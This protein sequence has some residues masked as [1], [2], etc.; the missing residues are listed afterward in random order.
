MERPIASCA[1]RPEPVP[2]PRKPSVRPAD[3]A[4]KN[5]VCAREPGRP[6]VRHHAAVLQVPVAA[7][8]FDVLQFEGDAVAGNDRDPVRASVGAPAALTAWRTSGSA[9]TSSSTSVSRSNSASNSVGPKQN[10][11]VKPRMLS[12]EVTLTSDRF[13]VP[14]SARNSSMSA[15]PCRVSLYVSWVASCTTC[16]AIRAKPLDTAACANRPKSLIWWLVT[17]VLTRTLS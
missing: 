14:A 16:S 11:G 6:I 1:S 9:R 13:S 15:S 12:P 7:R 4:E 5:S 10:A 2:R 8:S 3:R 17:L